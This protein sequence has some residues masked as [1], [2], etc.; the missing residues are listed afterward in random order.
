[1]NPIWYIE[2]E[3]SMQLNEYKITVITT[4]FVFFLTDQMDDAERI[5][6]E[7]E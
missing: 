1:M 2:I 3:I 5:G 7:N 6:A 4:V